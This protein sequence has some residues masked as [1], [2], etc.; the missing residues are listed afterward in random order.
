MTVSEAARYYGVSEQVVGRRL[1]ATEE[2]DKN[3]LALA[4][5]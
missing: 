1:R 4:M 3:Q 2:S 5:A